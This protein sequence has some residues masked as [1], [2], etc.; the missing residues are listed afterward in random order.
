VVLLTFAQ[1]NPD[2]SFT[3]LSQLEACRE[4]KTEPDSTERVYLNKL[5]GLL[6]T[7]YESIGEKLTALVKHK[8]ILFELLP[9]FLRSNE[10]VHM[11]AANS[12]K[13]RYLMFDSGQVKTYDVKK[14]FELSCRYLTHDGKC[15]RE[16]A[17]TIKILEFI[18]VMKITSLGVYLFKYYLDR[19]KIVEELTKRERKFMSFNRIRHRKYKG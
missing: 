16:A 1:I 5:I 17:A 3:Y 13:L 7:H 8:E 4:E 6:K 12:E 11:I 18:G 14:Y 15:F 2:I 9:V 10:V 19:Q